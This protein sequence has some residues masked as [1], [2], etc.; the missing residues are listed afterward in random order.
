MGNFR[1]GGLLAINP[2]LSREDGHTRGKRFSKNFKVF[3]SC[4]KERAW[5]KPNQ[6]KKNLTN[7]FQLES[8]KMKRWPPGTLRLTGQCRSSILLVLRAFSSD[9]T[10]LISGVREQIVHELF[11]PVA[12]ARDRAAQLDAPEGRLRRQQCTRE[13]VTLLPSNPGCWTDTEKKRLH[14]P[15]NEHDTEGASSQATDQHA[16]HLPED[17]PHDR[18]AARSEGKALSRS[19]RQFP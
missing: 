10:L 13:A 4:Q 1:K 19:D 18:S 3:E 7:S 16:E 15:P 6:P 5:G 8:K 14:Q 12:R 17:H 2:T 9:G 11:T